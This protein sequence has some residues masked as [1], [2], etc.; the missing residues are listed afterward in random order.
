LERVGRL[1]ERL[2][3]SS[4]DPLWHKNSFQQIVKK[5]R[6]L[7]SAEFA[8]SI[9]ELETMGYRV[10]PRRLEI[11]EDNNAERST[12]IIRSATLEG[13]EHLNNTDW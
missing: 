4:G 12:I 9:E 6:F 8:G 2:P 13:P 10:T 3:V 1:T 7:L 5:V 11:A